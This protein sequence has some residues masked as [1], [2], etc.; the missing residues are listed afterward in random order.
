M[1]ETSTVDS[2]YARIAITFAS[3]GLASAAWAQPAP[4]TQPA[5]PPAASQ[6]AR[7]ND[8]REIFQ[9]ADRATRAVD[10]VRYEVE[11]YRD[12]GKPLVTGTVVMGGGSREGLD[13][14]RMQLKRSVDNRELIIGSQGADR[15]VYVI[16]ARNK[17][18]HHGGLSILGPNT[19]L[20][21]AGG[22]R[23]FVHP[24]PFGDELEAPER[25]FRGVT[26]VAGEECYEVYVRYQTPQ[27]AVWFFSVKDFLPRRVDRDLGPQGKT[28]HVLRKLEVDP[29]FEKNPFD[30]DAPEGFEKTTTPLP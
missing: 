22:L 21:F 26:T 17:R 20:L 25:A 14:Y 28:R 13:R 24:E 18:I 16:D 4:T 1:G 30:A 3:V 5:A 27:S 8:P 23:E 12:G 6:P 29:K 19:E 10:T 2:M 7:L 9:R 11:F 15:G